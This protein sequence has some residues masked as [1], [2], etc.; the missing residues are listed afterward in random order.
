VD[1]E[2]LRKVIAEGSAV[3][4]TGAGFSSDARDTTGAPLP[5]AARMAEE[6]RELCYGRD[7][8]S[9]LQDLYDVATAK[10]P[11]ALLA[12]LKR[13]L[14]IGD[15]PLPEH[16]GLWFAA[17]WTRIYTLNVDDLEAAVV[18]QFELPRLP[19]VVHLN[20]MVGDDLG[21]MTFSTLQNAR[22]LIEPCPLYTQLIEDLGQRPFVFVGT[23]LDEP[24]FW[25]HL[26][27]RAARDGA[28]PRPRSHLITPHL[29]RARRELLAGLAIEWV[30]G[31]A[32]EVAEGVLRRVVE[33]PPRA[34]GSG[35]R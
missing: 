21:A 22:R 18:R 7:D 6:L 16:H 14:R 17:P 4:F 24:L 28:P 25:Q 30:R 13:R 34:T 31:T 32:A 10:H 27:L 26:Q 11:D 12:Y 1:L 23:M 29:S 3:L 19:E 33:P 20:G 35:S 5:L 15:H 2:R 8:D 9:S